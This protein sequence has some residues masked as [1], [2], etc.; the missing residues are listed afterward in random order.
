MESIPAQR[1]CRDLLL[2]A[3]QAQFSANRVWIVWEIGKGLY[4]NEPSAD[5]TIKWKCISPSL[6]ELGR[7]VT[8]NIMISVIRKQKTK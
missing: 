3:A 2:S 5:S 6:A 1:L 7:L 8:V 4:A